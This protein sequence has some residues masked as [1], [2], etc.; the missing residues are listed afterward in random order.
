MFLCSP[1]FEE[2]VIIAVVTGTWIASSF[3]IILSGQK[4]RMLFRVSIHD[5]TLILHC[6]PFT[7]MPP[8]LLFTMCYHDFI[9]HCSSFII[10][11]FG[12]YIRIFNVNYQLVNLW[13]RHQFAMFAIFGHFS[14]LFTAS[15]N[16]NYSLFIVPSFE[17]SACCDHSIIWAS[18]HL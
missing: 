12:V 7:T 8:V 17:L 3:C 9:L 1:E 4:T 6:L 15:H 18:Y 16:M 13:S 14:N 2:F 5:L 11:P 10:T